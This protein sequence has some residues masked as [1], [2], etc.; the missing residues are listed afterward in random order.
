MNKRASN[1]IAT[2]LTLLDY[3]AWL[4]ILPD[5]NRISCYAAGVLLTHYDK[6]QKR[7]DPCR[8]SEPRLPPAFHTLLELTNLG[9]FP[10]RDRLQN[11]AHISKRF[12]PATVLN[13]VNQRINIQMLQLFIID[14]P[15][16]R[17]CRNADLRL[18]HDCPVMRKRS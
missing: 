6:A 18:G 17:W 12:L 15:Q 4:N 7:L 1:R 8:S 11:V 16:N 13:T 9:I 2:R 14:L 5:R 3:K 10:H